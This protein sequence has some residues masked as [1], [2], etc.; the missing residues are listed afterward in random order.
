MA[1]PKTAKTL[2][3]RRILKADTALVLRGDF[4]GVASYRQVGRVFKE[5]Q[6]EG[7]LARI[8]QGVYARARP[9]KINGKIVPEGALPD[10][11]R[12][13]AARMG[14]NVVRTPEEQAYFEGRT[15][16]VPVGRYIGID[17]RSQKKLRWT[18]GTVYFETITAN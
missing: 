13:L 8:G 16:Q 3:E 5:L 2:I 9:S 12:E 14:A 6:R 4:E 10:L 15:T 11:A 7:K 17:K 1:R 18:R